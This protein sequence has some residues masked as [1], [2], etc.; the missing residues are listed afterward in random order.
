MDLSSRSIPS[1][2]EQERLAGS[3]CDRGIQPAYGGDGNGH[4]AGQ[5]CLREV[6][7]YRQRIYS[8]C[9]AQS[10]SLQVIF[11]AL[12]RYDYPEANEA[13]ERAFGALIRRVEE[14]Q[15]VGMLQQGNSRMLALMYLA[16]AIGVAKLAITGRLP[17]SEESRVVAFDGMVKGALTRGLAP[18][19]QPTKPP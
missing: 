9:S 5:N 18:E 2:S 15:A 16:I 14:C 17:F 3:G 11:D 12:Q 13:G 6:P 19:P 1:F 7:P 4:R 8:I 10:G